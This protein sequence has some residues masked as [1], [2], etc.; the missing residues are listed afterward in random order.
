MLLK[1]LWK[2]EKM[3]VTSIFSFSHKVFH[4]SQEE[5]LFFKLYLFSRLLMLA[6]STSWKFCKEL[7]ENDCYLDFLHSQKVFIGHFLQV[8]CTPAKQYVFVCVRNQHVWQSICPSACL[9]TKSHQLLLQFCCCFIELCRYLYIDHV[10]KLGKFLFISY[11]C[12][13]ASWGIKLPS[14]TSTS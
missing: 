14:V 11:F 10:L 4:S 13:S 1:T 2:K 6:I 8:C 5:F 3:L 9:G 7:G 12:Q